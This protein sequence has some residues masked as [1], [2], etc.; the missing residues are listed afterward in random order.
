MAASSETPLSTGNLVDHLFRHQ[1]GQM[2]SHLTRIFGF[3]N[4]DLAEDEGVDLHEWLESVT[5][6][7]PVDE[8]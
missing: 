8:A 6:E 2:V 7:V 5:E 1:A 4:L 3:E